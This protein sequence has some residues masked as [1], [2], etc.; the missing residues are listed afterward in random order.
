MK[1]FKQFWEEAKNLP[2]DKMSDKVDK[3]SSELQSKLKSWDI[4]GASK[5]TDR[6][7]KIKRVV[8]PPTD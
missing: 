8:L 3:L 5:I 4:I 7:G 2:V 6:V 1:T